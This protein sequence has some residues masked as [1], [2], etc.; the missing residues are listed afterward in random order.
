MIIVSTYFCIGC[1]SNSVANRESEPKFSELNCSLGWLGATAKPLARPGSI[2]DPDNIDKRLTHGG[3][4][5]TEVS[6]NGP[7]DEAGLVSGD[8]VA[9]VEEEWLPIK[10]NPARDMMA[11]IETQISAEKNE[12]SIGYLHKR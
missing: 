3:L 9:Q 10:E 6:P 8:I 1:E 5:L 4:L 2:I 12:I 11:I 7:L